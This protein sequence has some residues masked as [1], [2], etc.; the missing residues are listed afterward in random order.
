MGS[1]VRPGD[2][3]LLNTVSGK[4]ITVAAEATARMQDGTYE[5]IFVP[6]KS[7]TA[8]FG[9]DAF[10]SDIIFSQLGEVISA[11]IL[12]PNAGKRG[13]T[14]ARLQTTWGKGG[15]IRDQLAAG[16]LYGSRVLPLGTNE[17]SLDGMGFTRPHLVAAPASIPIDVQFPLGASNRLRRIYGFVWYYHCSSDVA[18]RTIR[19]S[20]RDMG[21]GLPV[22]MTSGGNTTA[23]VWPS[24]GTISLTANQEGMI[25]VTAEQQSFSVGVDTGTPTI[26]DNTTQP[27]SFPYWAQENDV[28]EIFFDVGAAET[29]DRHTIYLFMEEWVET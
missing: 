24:A 27:N 14:Y 5:T 19:A 20:L 16:Y 7:T 11:V 28:A 29:A 4:V 6:Q 22:G 13:Q 3:I 8:A 12:S 23:Q 21:D 9:E 17:G 18:T 10:R 26:E 1:L 25:Y 2:G 15:A